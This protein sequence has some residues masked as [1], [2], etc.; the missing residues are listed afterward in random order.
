[1]ETEKEKSAEG[2]KESDPL[3]E[4]FEQSV[5]GRPKRARVESAAIRRLR[6]GEGVMSDKPSGVV[7]YRKE[8]SR[9]LLRKLLMMTKQPPW[10][11]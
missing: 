7:N 5:E 9:A 1:V 4:G 8:S 11:Q 3:G 2:G 10:Q 6:T